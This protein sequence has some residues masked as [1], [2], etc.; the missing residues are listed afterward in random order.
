[1][2]NILGE[3]E[4]TSNRKM[5][6]HKVNATVSSKQLVTSSAVSMDSLSSSE[7]SE[8]DEDLSDDSVV[9]KGPRPAYSEANMH[10]SLGYLP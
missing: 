9:K 5:S 4:N 3:A 10:N 6:F 1:M 2:Q 8:S 7:E